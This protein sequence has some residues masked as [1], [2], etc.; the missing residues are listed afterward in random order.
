MAEHCQL[1]AGKP[2]TASSPKLALR[3]E[4]GLDVS[5]IPQALQEL[6][7]VDPREADTSSQPDLYVAAEEVTAEARII[8][9][10]E[11]R[12]FRSWHH[13]RAEHWEA[14]RV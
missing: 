5:L 3:A 7:V 10:Q 9:L 8:D 11:E 6:R 14:L 1:S 4:Q 12:A 2:V 13:P